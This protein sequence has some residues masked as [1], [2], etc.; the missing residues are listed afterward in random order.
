MSLFGLW[1]DVDEHGH[2]MDLYLADDGVHVIAVD[3][4]TARLSAE[5]AR[6]LRAALEVTADP[7]TRVPRN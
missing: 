4:Q 6:E 7:L 3:G 2:A 5:Q 1:A